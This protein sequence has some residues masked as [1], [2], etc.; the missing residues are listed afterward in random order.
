M[1]A[2]YC[3]VLLFIVTTMLLGESALTSSISY[4]A[5]VA[6]NM[7]EIVGTPSANG[8]EQ[9]NII[10]A[11]LVRDIYHKI[12]SLPAEPAHHICPMYIIAEYQLTFLHSGSPLLR[13]NARQGGCSTVSL[14]KGNVR[15]ADTAFWSL[16]ERTHE[17]GSPHGVTNT[18]HGLIP[19]DLQN[20]YGLP[21]T[22]AGKGQ[23]VAIVD[24]YDNPRA[25]TDMKIYRSTFGLPVCTTANGCFRKVDQRGGKRYPRADQGWAGEIALDLD[26]VSAICRNCHILLVEANSPSFDNLGTA[27]NIAVRLGANTISN[28]YGGQEDSQSAQTSARYYRHTGVIITASSGDD[29]YGV[30]LPAAFQGVVAVGGTSLMRA[31]NARGWT[32]VAW[33]GTGSGCSR[34]VSKPAWQQDSGCPNR[35]VADVSAVADP[36]TGVAVYHTYGGN[37]WNVFGGTSASSPIIASTYALAGN[38]K[39]VD[40][41][42]LYSH[43][44]NL[45]PVTQ[46]S[47][48][49][50]IPGYL[51][52]AGPGYNGPTGLGTPN[53][54]GAF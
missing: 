50:C 16:L 23:T 27:V 28:S 11:Q 17:L 45:N 53:G 6:P 2:R 44:A 36:A 33:N 35:T 26:M 10:Q 51:C 31:G 13:A 4:A 34:Y 48:G 37:G 24:A 14:G 38:A 7:L 49:T 42:Y 5:G 25:E 15:V 1:K 18:P 46:G 22:T 30:E 47:N 3:F 21:S 41:S 19:S 52:T 8:G 9:A 20:A 54:I 12:L 39:T 43:A 40:S 32:E 29:G